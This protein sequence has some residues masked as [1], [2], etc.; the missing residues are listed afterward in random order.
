[1]FGIITKTSGIIR[2]HLEK[3]SHPELAQSFAAD[4]T[5]HV[6]IRVNGGNDVNPP[7]RT[8]RDQLVQLSGCVRP[9][10]LGGETKV[11]FHSKLSKILQAMDKDER[12][13]RFHWLCI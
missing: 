7:G 12:L 4:E 10:V 5:S 2:A 3:H 8:F 6:V 1:G 13:R 9:F 11:I